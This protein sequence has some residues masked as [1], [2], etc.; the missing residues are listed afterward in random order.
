M[1]ANELLVTP[2]EYLKGVGPDRAGLLKKELNIYNYGDLLQHFPYRYIDRSKI[3]AISE[4][5]DHNTFIQL[6]GKFSR[7]EETGIGRANRLTAIFSDETGS[8]EIVWFNA[9]QWVKQYLKPGETYVLFGKPNVF[10]T[11][12]NFTHPELEL[13]SNF[14]ANPLLQGF[15][16]MYNTSEKMKKRG[17]DSKGMSKIIHQLIKTLK[18]SDIPEILPEYLISQ[19]RLPS[20]YEAYCNIHLPTQ[21]GDQTNA[22]R[23][24]KFEELFIQQLRMIKLQLSRKREKGHIFEQIGPSF[25]E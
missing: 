10:N 16:P 2:I 19:Y 18:S 1:F 17:L 15:Q 3:Y 23:R 11:K 6:K 4:I 20:R 25:N 14:E 12:L 13:F 5:S 8:V 21:P 9:I 24:L 22:E 7:M